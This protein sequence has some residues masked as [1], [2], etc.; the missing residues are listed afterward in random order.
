MLPDLRRQ[1]E[2][3]LRDRKRGGEKH[4]LR[5]YKTDMRNVRV[6][7]SRRRIRQSMK[8]WI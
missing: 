8:R 3:F 6:R 4:N 5:S 1:S 7:A 2:A